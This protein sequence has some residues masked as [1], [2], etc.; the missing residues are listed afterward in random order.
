M[1]I[2]DLLNKIANNGFIPIKIKYHNTE[3]FVH[4]NIF[5]EFMII[6]KDNHQ[7]TYSKLNDEVEVIE[8]S[9]KKDNKIKKIKIDDNSIN[10]DKVNKTGTTT[11]FREKDIEIFQCLSNKINELIDKVNEMSE[12]E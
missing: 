9:P 7:M 11:F 8:Y 12:K 6:D 4:T 10:I 1:K 3:Y 5:G 2:I